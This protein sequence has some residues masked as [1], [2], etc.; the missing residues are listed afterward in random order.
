MTVRILPSPAGVHSRRGPNALADAIRHA[1][2][3]IVVGRMDPDD[4]LGP[5]KAG[6]TIREIHH[7]EWHAVATAIGDWVDQ[8]ARVAAVVVVAGLALGAVAL[9]VLFAPWWFTVGVFGSGLVVLV[10]WRIAV[11]GR[12]LRWVV[13]DLENEER[14]L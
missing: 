10:V 6:L 13:E 9:V 3:L 7:R 5:W 2:L 4:Q 1:L 8:A 12:R 14:G 11:A